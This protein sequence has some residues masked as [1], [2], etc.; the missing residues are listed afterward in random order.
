MKNLFYVLAAGFLLASCT[1][2]TTCTCTYD[3][4]EGLETPATYMTECL[5]C[6]S[7]EREAF[8]AVC[9][10]SDTAMNIPGLSAG[11][12]VID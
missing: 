7:D 10:L 1:K 11:S 2:D 6:N 3:A 4:V 8:E 9:A 5:G 12:C